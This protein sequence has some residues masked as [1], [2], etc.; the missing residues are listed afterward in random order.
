MMCKLQVEKIQL[1]V[2]PLQMILCA[3]YAISKVTGK[4]I[5]FKQIVTSYRRLPFASPQVS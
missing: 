1:G 5:Q 4:E 2:Y 3:I